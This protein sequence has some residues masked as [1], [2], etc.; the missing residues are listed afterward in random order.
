MNTDVNLY[1]IAYKIRTGYVRLG[2]ILGNDLDEVRGKLCCLYG[3][4]DNEVMIVSSRLIPS[5][6]IYIV[7]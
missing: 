2:L 1:E 3:C 5:D 4:S 6:E 7:S